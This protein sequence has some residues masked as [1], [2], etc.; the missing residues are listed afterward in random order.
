[1]A[2][3]TTSFTGDVFI[4]VRDEDENFVKIPGNIASGTGLVTTVAVEDDNVYA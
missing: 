2:S 4:R 1:V 3:G